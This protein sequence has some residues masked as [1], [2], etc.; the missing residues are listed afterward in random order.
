[1]NLVHKVIAILMKKVA[2]KEGKEPIK[3]MPE[4]IAKMAAFFNK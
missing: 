1:M 3:K 4:N 2:A